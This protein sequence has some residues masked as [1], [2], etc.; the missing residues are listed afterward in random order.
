MKFKILILFLII[1]LDSVSQ[2]TDGFIFQTKPKE[3]GWNASIGLGGSFFTNQLSEHFDNYVILDFSGGINFSRFYIEAGISGGTTY[4]SK[5][6]LYKNNKIWACNSTVNTMNLNLYSCGYSFQLNRFV[7]SPNVGLGAILLNLKNEINDSTEWLNSGMLIA[8]LDIK[9][10]FNS[11][12]SNILYFVK[13]KISANYFNFSKEINGGIVNFS[14]GIG[15]YQP[16]LEL[17]GNCSG[18]GLMFF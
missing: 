4:I 16:K 17:D 11:K 1:H 12:Q 6:F 8:G 3:I 14:L 2:K 13:F 18:Y 7:L 15:F 5:E 10:V 9:Y